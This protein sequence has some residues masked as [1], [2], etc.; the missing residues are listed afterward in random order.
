[1]GAGEI[2][3]H[4]GTDDREGTLPT[5]QGAGDRLLADPPKQAMIAAGIV[6]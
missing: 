3:P 6:T 1:M 5:G 4:D 2:L